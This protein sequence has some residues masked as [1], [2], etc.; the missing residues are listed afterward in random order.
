M[1]TDG[2]IQPQDF[3]P[4]YSPYSDGAILIKADDKDPNVIYLMASNE[5]MDQQKDITILKALEEEVENFLKKGVI[6]W[7]HLH[8]IEKN[9]DYIIGEPLD[10]QFKEDSTWT[11]AK[12]YK[13]VKYA[14]SVMDLLKSGTT[15]LGASIGG[16]IKKRKPLSKSVSAILKIIWDEIAITY[17][18][19]N[20]TTMGNVSMIPMGAFAK[21]LTAGGGVDA[22]FM[23]GGRAMIPESLQGHVTKVDTVELTEEFVWRLQ[24]GDIRTDADLQIFLEHRG[25]PHLY[26]VFAKKIIDKFGR[27]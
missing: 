3:D 26:N 15:R 8:K 6:S 1:R 11:K 12:L 16:F 4:F 23:T 13:S 17:K 5:N 14:I 25:V 2:I 18:P 21:A 20:D 22:A 7:D 9:P 24:K 19:V 10:V 27:T